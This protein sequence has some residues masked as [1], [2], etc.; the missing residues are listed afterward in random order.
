M[1][2]ILSLFHNHIQSYTNYSKCPKL[3]YTKVSDKVAYANSADPDQTA[4]E[5]AVWSG[6]T[7]FTVP[8]IIVRNNCI[9]NK[10]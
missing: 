10:L 8:L 6:S 7:L 1:A 2:K 4:F 9:K 3:S 5:G